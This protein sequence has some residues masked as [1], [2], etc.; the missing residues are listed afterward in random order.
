[1]S[2]GSNSGVRVTTPRSGSTSF[3]RSPRAPLDDAASHGPAVRVLGTDPVEQFP[4]IRVRSARARACAA[5]SLTCARRRSCL[6][7]SCSASTAGSSTSSLRCRRGTRSTG[8]LC[9]CAP[10]APH[11]RP[12][13]L[14]ALVRAC[15]ASARSRSARGRRGTVVW[16]DS[17]ID[18][19]ELAWQN[20]LNEKNATFFHAAGSLFTKCVC[21]FSCVRA[22]VLTPAQLLVDPQLGAAHGRSGGP[23]RQARRLC[24]HR[25][26]R[27]SNVRR[28]RPQQ[29]PGACA[30]RRTLARRADDASRHWAFCASTARPSRCS[31]PRGP[32]SRVA[33]APTFCFTTRCSGYARKRTRAACLTPLSRQDGH[34]PK[35]SRCINRGSVSAFV[36]P[37]RLRLPCLYT[38]Y[39]SVRAAHRCCARRRECSPCLHLRRGSAARSLCTARRCPRG[40]R[41]TP[42]AGRPRSRA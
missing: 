7:A 3:S 32:T 38:S 36:P 15:C 13:C 14:G 1:M 2:G 42:T 33:G 31:R 16:Y 40:R 35:S 21:A 27:P 28:W 17:V 26:A 11:S 39:D 10:C 30:L 23:A 5:R 25:S 22:S 19:G 6:R 8:L 34:T 18:T 41:A 24:R 29:R 37:R 4:A 20:G 12:R 9:S